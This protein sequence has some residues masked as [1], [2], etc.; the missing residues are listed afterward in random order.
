MGDDWDQQEMGMMGDDGEG[1]DYGDEGGREGPGQKIQKA[2]CSCCIGM[3]VFPLSLFLLGWNEKNYVCTH[4]T[5]LYAED[6]AEDVGC[7]PTGAEDTFGFFACPIQEQGLQVFTP[8]MFNVDNKQMPCGTMSGFGSNISFLSSAGKQTVEM[9]QCVEHETQETRGSG[10]NS[11]TRTVYTYSVDWSSSLVS[12]FNQ[13]HLAQAEQ[14]CPG[15]FGTNPAFPTNVDAGESTDYAP[16]PV[17]AGTSNISAWTINED[18]VRGIEPTKP[19]PLSTMLGP[20]STFK[21]TGSV[22]P[23]VRPLSVTTLNM[24]VYGDY[25]ST[26][27]QNDNRVGCVRISYHMAL[28]VGESPAVLA[29]VKESVTS[30]EKVPSSW[31]CSASDRQWIRAETG[32]GPYTKD[33]LIETLKSENSMTTWLL[34]LVGCILAWVSVFCCLQPIAA[35]ADIMGDCLAFIPCV[36]GAM[37]DCLEGAV[38]SLLC[39]LSCGVGCSCALFVIATMWVVMRPMVGIPLMLLALC[40]GCSGIGVFMSMHK[41]PKR[42]NFGE[43]ELS[44]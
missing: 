21:G 15:F 25:L 33:T 24:L 3:L 32:S 13:A 30:P 39:C 37:E 26:C 18:L 41:K 10:K 9:L 29:R 42:K 19:V 7:A 40:V 31:G 27:A 22:N 23:A 28:S 34:R 11:R 44:D 36:G 8:C 17:K 35:A 20:I 4:N 5:I 2:F 6:N 38:D 12:G 43:V 1:G 16:G 14:S